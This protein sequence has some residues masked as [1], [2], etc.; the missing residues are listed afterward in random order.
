MGM[1][2][3]ADGAIKSANLDDDSGIQPIVRPGAAGTNTPKQLAVEPRGKKL[4]F[5]D[6]EGQRALRCGYDGA[7]L[8]TLVQTGDWE[9]EGFADKTKWCVGIAVSRKLGKFIG[10]RRTRPRL[11]RGASCVRVSR[12]LRGR[13]R[14]RGWTSSCCL[15]SCLNLLTLRLMMPVGF[16][17]GLIAASC[18]LEIL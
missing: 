16:C 3:K 11:A 10:R 7:G 8:E 14:V 4:Y 12:C 9:A 6:R 13:R 18:L 1:P 2:G 5:C 15:T 17:I